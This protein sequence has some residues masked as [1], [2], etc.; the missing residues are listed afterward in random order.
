MFQEFIQ[1]ELRAGSHDAQEVYNLYFLGFI[2]QSDCNLY[3]AWM[4]P[5]KSYCCLRALRVNL[6]V[7]F[8]LSV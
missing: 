2:L 4:T 5:G 1:V 3:S 8:M 6:F 7:F